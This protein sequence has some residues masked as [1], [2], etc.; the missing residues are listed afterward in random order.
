MHV[1]EKVVDFKEIAEEHSL[2]ISTVE[3]LLD[4]VDNQNIGVQETSKSPY[5]TESE[6]MVVKSFLT[7]RLHEIQVKSMHHSEETADFQEGSDSDLQSMPDDEL[8]SVSGFETAESDDFLDNEMS[9]SDH[10]VQDDNASTECISLLD[11]MDHICEEV[12]S[13]HSKL[14]DMESS[15]AEIKSSLPTLIT[16]GLKYQLHE[17]LSATLKDCFPSII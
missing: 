6:I 17:L 12:S 11:H 4:E 5:D 9:T 15:I 3:Q 16:N 8:R 2:E 13:L 10:I 1:P 14:G 7:S